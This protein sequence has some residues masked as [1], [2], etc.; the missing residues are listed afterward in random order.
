[1]D[2]DKNKC[3]HEACVCTVGEDEEYCGEYCTEAGHQ[4]M[5]QISCDCGHS[6][7]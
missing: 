7:C 4:D 2:E 3:K 1:M 5:T 6:C